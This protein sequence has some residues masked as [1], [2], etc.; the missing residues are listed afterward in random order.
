MKYGAMNRPPSRP[1]AAP[2]IALPWIIRLRYGLAVGQLV[3]VVAVH[4]LLDID[5]PLG[6]LAIPPLLT[7]LSNLWLWRWAARPE[8][9]ERLGP[10][11]IVAWVFV[12][13]TL[14]L[15]ALLMLSGGPNNP[16]SLLYLVFITLSSAILTKRQTWALGGLATVCFALLFRIYRPI[17]NLEMHQVAAGPNLHLIGMWVGFGV[18]AFLVAM[19]SG[20]ISELL[21][22]REDSLM[23]MQIELAKK[24]R[25]ASLVTLAAGAAH[26]LSTP[27]ATIAVVAKE[28]ERSAAGDDPASAGASALA[29]DSRLIRTEVERCREILAR[30]S[31]A[32]A[33]PTGETAEAVPVANLLSAVVAG[34]GPAGRVRVEL[35]E[36]SRALELIAPRH[37]VEQALIALVKN[38]MH[39]S[40]ADQAVTIS[41]TADGALLRLRVQDRGP[42]MSAETL[43]HVG[44]PFF[45]TKEPGQGMGLGVFLV[46]TLAG[47]LGGRLTFESAPG[48]GTVATLELPLAAV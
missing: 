7:M 5:L 40:P 31:A 23:E 47:R 30:M 13:D 27:L 1:D 6:W 18:A 35:S 11:R 12:L 34:F 25:L 24:D 19:F 36:A 3:T 32:G 17:P 37:A 45:T 14:C 43:R 44:E 21:K 38:A 28:L 48:K 39:A 2:R 29:E 26:E 16:F 22:E 33:E 9:S 20:K 41:A 15:T 4:Q 46:R 42:G 8:I 10:S